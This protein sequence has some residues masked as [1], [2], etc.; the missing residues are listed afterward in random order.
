MKVVLLNPHYGHNKWPA[1]IL[2]NVDS[3]QKISMLSS[4]LKITILYYNTLHSSIQTIPENS[5]W[6]TL[7]N[8]NILLLFT[9]TDFELPFGNVLVNKNSWSNITNIP[10]NKPFYLSQL[11]CGRLAS[12][13]ES[14][15]SMN[16]QCSEI[17]GKI[18]S[19]MIR[20]AATRI[21][22]DPTQSVLELPVNSIDSYRSLRSSNA[23]SVG[24]FGMGFFSILYWILKYP[25]TVLI[26][27]STPRKGLEWNLKIFNNNGILMGEFIDKYSNNDNIV[28]LEKM[29]LE[30]ESNLGT[31]IWLTNNKSTS[32]FDSKYETK[33]ISKQL[34]KLQYI[35]DVDIYE[36]NFDDEATPINRSLKMK[37]ETLDH[38]VLIEYNYVQ[39]N[40]LA[41]NLYSNRS[42]KMKPEASDDIVLIEYNYTQDS[43]LYNIR[44]QDWAAGIPLEI[45][46]G[47]LL[48]P[49]VSTKTIESSYNNQQNQNE[50]Y[51]V[52]VHKSQFLTLHI[53]IGS[54]IVV[55][56]E[57]NDKYKQDNDTSKEINE[58]MDEN[59]LT[60]HLDLP[61]WAKIPVSRDDVVVESY[62]IEYEWL[63]QGF[64][65]MIDI[66]LKSN[67]D[68][69]DLIILIE[70]Y[71]SYSNQPTVFQIITKLYDYLHKLDNVIYLPN[72]TII[73]LLRPVLNFDGHIAHLNKSSIS[74]ASNQLLSSLKKSPNIT[75]DTSFDEV[76]VIV[77]PDYKDIPVNCGLPIFVFISSDLYNKPNWIE[78]LIFSYSTILL[79]LKNNSDSDK[80]STHKIPHEILK[81]R[82]TTESSKG[83]KTLIWAKSYGFSCE[84]YHF[85]LLEQNDDFFELVFNLKEAIENCLRRYKSSMEFFYLVGNYLL[86]TRIL[87]KDYNLPYSLFQE[88]VFQFYNC[89]TNLK[90]V[91]GEGTNRK[92]YIGQGICVNYNAYSCDVINRSGLHRE[93]L[94]ILEPTTIHRIIQIS[95]DW[96]FDQLGED[97]LLQTDHYYFSDV[98]YDLFGVLI[99]IYESLKNKIDKTDKLKSIMKVIG[100]D[101]IEQNLSIIETYSILMLLY[102]LIKQEAEEHVLKISSEKFLLYMITEA[103]SNY[104]TEFFAQWKSYILSDA[105]SRVVYINQY[106]ALFYDP[107]LQKLNLYLSQDLESISYCS[108]QNINQVRFSFTA[109]QLIN[110]VF[111]AKL[112]KVNDR[113]DLTNLLQAVSHHVVNS[114][115]EFQ[116]VAIAVNEGTSKPFVAS[117]LTELMQNSIDAIRANI[118]RVERKIDLELCKSD[119]LQFSITDYVGIPDSSMLA[120]LI[121]FLSSKSVDDMMSTGEMG[122]GFFNVYRQPYCF[123]VVIETNDLIIQAT[124][125]LKN[126]RVYD[127]NYEFEFLYEARIGTKITIVF[128]P[129]SLEQNITLIVDLRIT[130]VNM[131]RLSPFPTYFNS[132]S[133][134]IVKQTVYEDNTLTVYVSDETIQSFLL[135]NGVPFGPLI[136]LVNTVIPGFVEAN[137]YPL[138]TNVIIDFK[139]GEYIPTQSRHRIQGIDD[140]INSM[141]RGLWY[142]LTLKLLQPEWTST[143]K[144]YL[145]QV[146]ASSPIDT[147]N[148]YHGLAIKNFYMLNNFPVTYSIFE[149]NGNDD[150]TF[151]LAYII[152]RI[153]DIYEEKTVTEQN[154]KRY[155][156]E[157]INNDEI[158]KLT[159]NYDLI[160]KMVQLFFKDK[161]TPI[162]YTMED[163]RIEKRDR[164]DQM[165]EKEKNIDVTDISLIL[166]KFVRAYYSIGRQIKFDVVSFYDEPPLV[167]IET[168]P[169]STSGYYTK[170]DHSIKISRALVETKLMSLRQSWNILIQLYKE[171]KFRQ[172]VQILQTSEWS[173]FIGNVFPMS[174]LVHELQH[175]I[176][177]AD[178]NSTG[179][180]EPI[181]IGDKMRGFDD[182]SQYVYERILSEGFMEKFMESVLNDNPEA[183]EAASSY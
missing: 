156:D 109:N 101:I 31:S 108:E 79:S 146:F 168:I 86:S 52:E 92:I 121:P 78:N 34:E 124:P 88:Y 137:N 13:Y 164:M 136:P 25:E 126:N 130:A 82:Y 166:N 163:M 111:E 15:L 32:L 77:L 33:D 118:S 155:L 68:L 96:F 69:Q 63:L 117:V 73:N 158:D 162:K 123:K 60:Y 97:Y 143:L 100:N 106:K 169:A 112:E 122:T 17:S 67:Y 83:E 21:F 91:R 46:F 19:S 183:A 151:F 57:I 1:Y 129:I 131:A 3:Q 177:A 72:K 144:L 35:S 119:K 178:H 27:K 4:K 152:R 128:E 6:S 134:Q 154:I 141:L 43:K 51:H 37:P 39:D 148:E 47:S 49:S 142:A 76:Y 153:A 94:T 23:A 145:D 93:L 8:N 55:N 56:Q 161:Y 44:F 59:N 42:P 150:H 70:R 127:I 30:Y 104:N 58:N 171:N 28:T 120:L 103:R 180:H 81:D 175:S 16:K 20:V 116:S 125:I 149:L 107:M 10:L 165:Q 105:R 40:I 71:S 176:L 84:E 182:A 53:S 61:I 11:I 22:A 170:Y 80:W 95:S 38:I 99:H 159:I 139:R 24:K 48:I 9:V 172:M 50:T 5:V 12:T 66:C 14:W 147:L 98:R 18:A 74:Q 110:Y 132:E 62:S 102:E 157:I 41:H 138:I 2:V 64:I 45:L 135:T 90:I 26:I 75:I 54:I 36:V 179:A 181:F 160:E 89:I 7:F 133:Y 114:E 140:K 65:S 174:T 85:R 115:I 87:I 113:S 173:E 29:N 167:A